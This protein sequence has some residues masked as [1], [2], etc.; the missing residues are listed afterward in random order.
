MSI[1]DELALLA[2]TKENLRI[3]LGLSK[4]VPFSQYASNIPYY[5]KAGT[6]FD[7]VN[8]QY[9][10][11]QLPVNISDISEFIRL[12][13]ATMWQDERLIEVQNNIPRISGEGLLI[14]PQRTNVAQ[15]FTLW[16]PSSGA[17]IVRSTIDTYTYINT[18]PQVGAVFTRAEAVAS[19]K[20]MY[21]QAS[22]GG[23]A[24]LQA[25]KAKYDRYTLSASQIRRYKTPPISVSAWGVFA[26]IG[27]NIL[28]YPQDEEGDQITSYI[29]VGFS[30]T[31][32]SPDILNIPLLPTQSITGDWDEGVTYEIVDNIATFTGHGYI[33]NIT[34]EA[35]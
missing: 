6:V 18:V 25:D 2:N 15:P 35:L 3:S 22:E 11:D 28:R 19:I 29:P 26:P 10:K 4:D 14:E 9:S 34:V 24:R 17:E 20:S 23:E 33:R 7:F 8:N 21:V 13:S 1:A 32:R 30:P 12:S 27:Q 16:S 5:A 31:T